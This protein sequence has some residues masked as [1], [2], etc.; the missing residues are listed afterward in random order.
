MAS[1]KVPEAHVRAVAKAFVEMHQDPVG[2]DILRRAS[3]T[4]GLSDQAY[5]IPS[6]DADYANY[7]RF[8]QKAPPS[9][10]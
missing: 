8:Y 4:V 9:L 7:R 6:S 3:E 2:R 5:F 1:S 10:R